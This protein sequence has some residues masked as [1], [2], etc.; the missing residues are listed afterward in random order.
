MEYFWYTSDTIPKGLGFSHYGPMHVFWLI[1]AVAVITLCSFLYRKQNE[2]GRSVFRK[3]VAVL[4]IAD[5][6]FKLIPAIIFGNFELDLLPFHLCS[7]NLFVIAYH[8]WKPNKL[9]DNFLYTV[10]IPG[11]LAALLFPSWTK[12]PALNY[13]CI[14]SFTVHI[15]LVL[16]PVML[17]V[18]GDIQPKLREVPKCLLLLTGLA[19]IALILNLLWDTNY[20]FLMYANSGN[21]LKWFETAW[22]NHLYGFPVIIAGVIVVL[23]T[24]WILHDRLKR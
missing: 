4:L 3:A 18:G 14:H 8:A 17:T 13:M 15:L 22:G 23:Y 11:A 1:T 9:M 20:M 5:E 7:I 19:G 2:Q 16:Y 12:L 21:P 24:P 6:L 10:C